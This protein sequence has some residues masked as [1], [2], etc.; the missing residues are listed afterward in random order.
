MVVA[1]C[2]SRQCRHFRFACLRAVHECCFFENPR[3]KWNLTV[4]RCSNAA[5]RVFCATSEETRRHESSHFMFS[6]V[7]AD[8]VKRISLEFIQKFIVNSQIFFSRETIDLLR[9]RKCSVWKQ[10]V[11]S[12]HD[13]FFTLF[14]EV[15]KLSQSL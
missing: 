13:D 15:L 1:R 8:E 6:D 9:R 4:V 11:K 3:R 7:F 12:H 2:L 10:I 14:D 5:A